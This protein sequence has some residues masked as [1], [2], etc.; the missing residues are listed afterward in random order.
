M[1]N[2]IPHILIIDD[3][4]GLRVGTQRLLESE[5]YYVETAENGTQGIKLGTGNNFDIAVIDMKMPDIDGLEVLKE[6]KKA[7]PNT[8]CIIAT[9]YA[10]IETASESTRQGA[11]TYIPKPFTPEEL[12]YQ[13]E[14][15]YKQRILLLE[16]ERLKKEREEKLLELASEKSRLSTII[17]SIQDGV[18]VVNKKGDLVYY[19]H[20]AIKYLNLPKIELGEEILSRLP[21]EISELIKTYLK[22]DKINQKSYTLSIEILPQ[23]ELVIEAVLNPIQNPDGSPAGVVIVSRNITEFKKIETI[24]SQFV[25]MVAHELKTPVAA[26]LGYMKLI[27]DPNI[28]VGY[29][30]QMDYITRSTIR[31]QDMIDLVNDLLDISRM[32][33]KSKIREI[34]EL[35]VP[36]IIES[37]LS[38]LDFE[39]I[40]KGIVIVKNYEEDIPLLNADVNEIKRIYTNLLSNAV[41]YNNDKGN[42]RIELKISGNY[43]ITEISDTGIGMK[44][45]ECE[46]LF[47]EFYRAKN[48]LTR[49]ISGTGLGLSIV[50]RIIDAYHGTIK[51]ESEFEKGTKFTVS[52]P[53]DKQTT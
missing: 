46:K 25:S 26:V 48:K 41:K 35:N 49:G 8:I 45:E 43:L 37:V 5:G 30:Q 24:K 52:L 11:Y 39:I 18:L 12:L 47:N 16:S 17:S 38:N 32:E 22:S 3:E 27:L 33:L 44:P 1:E 29:E 21:L 40:K 36:E 2:N 10:S 42:I 23:N 50:K 4:K 13:I 51:V 28:P 19:N 6:I 7:K 34:E 31:L 14:R 20:A 15:G 9:A 53:I